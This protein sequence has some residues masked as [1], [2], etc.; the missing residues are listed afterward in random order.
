MAGRWACQVA[1]PPP[2]PPKKSKNK[3]I[4]GFAGRLDLV[5]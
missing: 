4:A 2:P 5:I 1:T 3:K